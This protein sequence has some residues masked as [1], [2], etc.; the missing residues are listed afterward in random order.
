MATV[1]LF[2]Q[3]HLR[4]PVSVGTVE[5][6]R[7]VREHARL[8]L[9]EAKYLVDRCVFDGEPVIIPMQTPE[10]AAALVDALRLIPRGATIDASVED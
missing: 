2:I 4:G 10:D 7:L 8:G 9:S 5:V 6:I 1:R 3:P